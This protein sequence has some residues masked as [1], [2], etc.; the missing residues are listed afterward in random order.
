MQALRTLKE[1]FWTNSETFA[2]IRQFP[3][4]LWLLF[5]MHYGQSFAS[6]MLSASLTIY[7]RRVFLVSTDTETTWYYAIWTLASIVVG[8]PGGVVIEI[9][10]LWWSLFV[11]SAILT[12]SRILFAFSTNLTLS[13]C[14]LFIGI[15]IGSDIVD[16]VLD[17]A[18]MYYTESPAIQTIVYG[19]LYGSMNFG[20]LC[21]F[22]LTDLLLDFSVGWNGYR[23]L[24]TVGAAAS[25]I[26]S[27][28]AYNYKIPPMLKKAT[29]KAPKFKLSMTFS[30][31]KDYQFWQISGLNFLLSGVGLIF[32][33][34]ETMLVT[35][36]VRTNESVRYGLILSI[37][38]LLIIPLA[39]FA[40]IITQRGLS[41]FW[42]IVVGSLISATS[43]AWLWLWPGSTVTAAVLCSVQ[44]TFG[45]SIWGPKV[46]QYTTLRSP[47][48][49]KAIYA[50]WIPLSKIPAT[51]L[52]GQVAGY[53]LDTHCPSVELDLMGSSSIAAYMGS[54][55]FMWGWIFLLALSSPTLLAAFA[56]LINWEPKQP[57]ILVEQEKVEDQ[58][59]VTELLDVSQPEEKESSEHIEEQ[60]KEI[61]T[62]EAARIRLKNFF[63]KL[64]SNQA[65]GT[66]VIDE[67]FQ[68]P[69]A[70]YEMEDMT[71]RKLDDVKESLL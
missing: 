60:G 49:K 44:I 41:V 18:V 59:K 5:F 69:P 67:K 7:L 8:I 26:C 12:V 4:Q 17:I 21:A 58:Q 53:L 36:L 31:F 20:A 70:D 32:R 45:E 22:N 1:R 9:F 65:R 3:L 35:Y 43:I 27:L 29:K 25:I 39:S 11:G 42:W 10:G 13:L 47:Q 57:V 56:K 55:R 23:L 50:G 19:I 33:F 40:A 63:L 61:T 48:G 34:I 66:D 71:D 62:T 38:P 46:K 24:F 2:A 6:F 28:L 15:S 64:L 68:P 37:N 30:L 54:C 52:S 16:S 51:I 14:T